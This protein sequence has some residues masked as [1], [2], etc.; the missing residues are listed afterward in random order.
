MSVVPIPRPPGAGGQ[1]PLRL[2][3]PT[4]ASRRA[5]SQAQRRLLNQLHVRAAKTQAVLERLQ[6]GEASSRD[7]LEVGG[8]RY[9]SRVY[10]LR[11]EGWVIT[12]NER[13]GVF[14]YR[15]EGRR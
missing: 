15:F 13:A 14:W 2:D 5:R 9:A 10:E 11:R 12:C 7:L 1:L 4:L 6:A 8:L 3:P